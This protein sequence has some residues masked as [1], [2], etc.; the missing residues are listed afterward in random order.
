[1]LRLEVLWYNRSWGIYFV[2]GVQDLNRDFVS[3]DVGLEFVNSSFGIP[4]L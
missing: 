3:S 1:M 4:L 2:G